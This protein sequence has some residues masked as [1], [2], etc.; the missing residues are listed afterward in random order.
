MTSDRAYGLGDR[1]N[2]SQAKAE[3]RT[4]ISRCA[5]GDA[6]V[7]NR[8]VGGEREIGGHRPRNIDRQRLSS[9]ACRRRGDAFRQVFDRGVHPSTTTTLWMA[10]SSSSGTRD[11]TSLSSARHRPASRRSR[12]RHP[13]DFRRKSHRPRNDS[14]RRF[15]TQAIRVECRDRERARLLE[16]GIREATRGRRC[17]STRRSR[18]TMSIRHVRR[19]AARNRYRRTRRRARPC[20]DGSPRCCQAMNRIQYLHQP[21]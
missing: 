10:S 11:C 14:E 8:R 1:Q 16:P 17:T 7:G 15:R 2:T 6:L 19:E 13:R 20:I 3:A 18:C 21:V 9:P 4:A 5:E 12:G